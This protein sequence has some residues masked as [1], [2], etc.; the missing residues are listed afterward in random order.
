LAAAGVLPKA[1]KAQSAASESITGTPEIV[2]FM[3]LILI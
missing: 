3:C 2:F 1:A